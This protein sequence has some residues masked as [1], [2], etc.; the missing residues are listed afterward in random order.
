MATAQILQWISEAAAGSSWT[1]RVLIVGDLQHIIVATTLGLLGLVSFSFL[2]SV[3]ISIPPSFF[4]FIHIVL[5]FHAWIGYHFLCGLDKEVA[6][7]Y[8]CLWEF[9]NSLY[10]PIVYVAFCHPLLFKNYLELYFCLN[11][12]VYPEWLENILKCSWWSNRDN[13]VKYVN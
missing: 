12:F 6:K 1:M 2:S 11:V 13:I 7:N 4:F 10:F 9:D 5:V 3:K 8:H